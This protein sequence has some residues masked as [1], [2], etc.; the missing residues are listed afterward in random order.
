[1]STTQVTEMHANANLKKA[2]SYLDDIKIDNYAQFG[3]INVKDTEEINKQFRILHCHIDL[4][5]IKNIDTA[6]RTWEGAMEV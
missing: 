6:N 2:E 3:E 4:V 5:N 1:M